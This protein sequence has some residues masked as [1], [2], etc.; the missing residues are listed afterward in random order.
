[1]VV[2]NAKGLVVWYYR[3]DLVD[4]VQTYCRCARAAGLAPTAAP[5][6]K[7]VRLAQKMQVGPCFPVGIHL[8]I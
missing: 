3:S 1:M 2:L 4:T 5:S 7:D 8:C 6:E